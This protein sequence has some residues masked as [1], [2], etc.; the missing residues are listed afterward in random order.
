MKI[1]F[2]PLLWITSSVTPTSYLC[3][4]YLDLLSHLHCR[5]FEMW[6]DFH[7]RDIIRYNVIGGLVSPDRDTI[8]IPDT[9]AQKS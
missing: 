4:L 6:D 3:V 9:K 7:S 8:Q 5:R 1:V 2:S